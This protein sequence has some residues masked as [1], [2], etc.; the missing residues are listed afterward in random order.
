M[1]YTVHKIQRHLHH[2]LLQL[3]PVN[4]DQKL[5]FRAGQYVAIA[6][7]SQQKTPYR[8]FSI[9]SS[10]RNELLELAFRHD[11]DVTRTI[12]DLGTEDTVDVLGPYGEFVLPSDE[13]PVVLLASGIGVT[14]FISMLREA[15]S[16]RSTRA[17]SLLVTGK[18]SASIPYAQELASVHRLAPTISIDVFTSSGEPGTY[19]RRID[20]AILRELVAASDRDSLYYVCGPDSFV[21][22]IRDTLVD[23]G[24][25]DRSIMT[26][27]FQQVAKTHANQRS[28]YAS[29]GL[30]LALGVGVIAA[31]VL[32]NL[33]SL[34][35]TEDTASSTSTDTT[36]T[37]SDTQA[38]SEE[39]AETTSESSTGSDNTS[40][41]TSDST[42]SY[43]TTTTTTDSSAST[44]TS[45]AS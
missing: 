34:A 44:T 20:A 28:K 38:S 4:S 2:T 13:R 31:I 24:V 1:R 30:S 7:S 41:T 35:A 12:S 5:S 3:K 22:K 16:Q 32:A 26:E 42:Q 8:C 27:S 45:T 29:I 33:P 18:Q 15:V 25:G 39:T 21:R 43:S 17:I 11:S 19:R 36:S 37:S 23:E 14:P 6:T 9:V 10:P 40:E